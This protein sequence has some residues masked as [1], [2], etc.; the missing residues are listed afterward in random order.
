MDFKYVALVAVSVSVSAVPSAVHPFGFSKVTLVK[1]VQL[2][3]AY[4]PMLVT[5]A[6]IVTLVKESQQRNADNPMLFN[7]LFAANVTLAKEV[8]P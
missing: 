6:G 1:E 2:R 7:W 3:N 8:H 4:D 5:L